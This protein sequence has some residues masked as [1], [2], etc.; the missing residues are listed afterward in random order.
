MTEQK[1]NKEDYS[2]A[3]F[4]EGQI[5]ERTILQ[6]KRNQEI[7]KLAKQRDNYTC[8]VCG[9]SYQKKIVEAHHLIPISNKS[10]EYEIKIENL[11]TLCPNCHSLAHHLLNENEIYVD[12]LSLIPKLKEIINSK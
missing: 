3:E 11:I 2:E 10:N 4:L 5:K 9:F 7:V 8:R 1:S 6:R 12:K